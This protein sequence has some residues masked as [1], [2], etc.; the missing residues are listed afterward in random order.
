MSQRY[1]HKS[2]D[3]RIAELRFCLRIY[4]LPECSEYN[5]ICVFKNTLEVPGRF[6]P[7]EVEAGHQGLAGACCLSKFLISS[8]ERN[9]LATTLSSITNAGVIITP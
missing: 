2:G 3:F 4:K 1:L 5:P 8:T 6:Y 9:P 7:L